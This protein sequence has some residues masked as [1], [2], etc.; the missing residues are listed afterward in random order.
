MVKEVG[1]H[2]YIIKQILVKSKIENNQSFFR[3]IAL[4]ENDLQMVLLQAKIKGELRIE[5]TEIKVLRIGNTNIFLK[6][7]INPVKYDGIFYFYI[8]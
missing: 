8:L 4:K 1:V 3:V 6:S 2:G 7:Y 5:C